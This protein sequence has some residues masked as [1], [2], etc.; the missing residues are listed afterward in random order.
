MRS[1]TPSPS[2][3]YPPLC[4]GLSHSRRHPLAPMSPAAAP[5]PRLSFTP[6]LTCLCAGCNSAG[7]H[8]ACRVAG[9]SLAALPTPPPE[10]NSTARAPTLAIAGQQRVGAPHTQAHTP[11][12]C[13]A[14]SCLKLTHCP[15]THA[16]VCACPASL[17]PLPFLKL[18]TRCTQPRPP[19]PPSPFLRHTHDPCA[20]AKQSLQNLCDPL[21]CPLTLHELKCQLLLHI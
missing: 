7:N 17:P 16:C 5:H 14:S 1:A 12:C 4:V 8:T 20:G 21:P 10:L 13:T 19:L 15:D 2:T 18:C 9:T 11:S 6:L 3:L